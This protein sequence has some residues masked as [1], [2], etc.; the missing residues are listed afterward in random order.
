MRLP[1]S[2]GMSASPAVVWVLLTTPIR[3]RE[4]ITYY[5]AYYTDTGGTKN[6]LTSSPSKNERM[7]LTQAGVLGKASKLKSSRH[8]DRSPSLGPIELLNLLRELLCNS[9]SLNLLRSRDEPA[10]RRPFVRGQND[11]LQ[12]L[13]RLERVLLAQR[14]ALLQHH[15][16]HARV[17]TEL[18]HRQLAVD[19]RR[20][21][22]TRQRVA[23]VDLVRDHDRDRLLRVGRGVHA[24]VGD[25][26]ARLVH[27]F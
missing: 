7:R 4:V 1:V 3:L 13:H 25:V 14:I 8:N 16:P 17:G 11:T 27:G 12:E 6:I 26:V 10:L 2:V 5:C 9:R 19:A 20:V 23:Q 24:D 15:L 22:V 18:V 21:R